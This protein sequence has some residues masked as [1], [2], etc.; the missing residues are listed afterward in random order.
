MTGSQDYQLVYW[1]VFTYDYKCSE[2]IWNNDRID[3]DNN[4]DSKLGAMK[5]GFA[6][7]AVNNDKIKYSSNKLRSF[8]GWQHF[9][10]HFKND[11]E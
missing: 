2:N 7:I 9:I 11:E 3:V 1:S 8:I 4:N 6:V 10:I 5:I